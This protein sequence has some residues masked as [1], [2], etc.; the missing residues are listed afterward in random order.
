[1]H[2]HV[3][4]R[5]RFRLSLSLSLVSIFF[6]AACNGGI[7]DSSSELTR[8]DVLA[9]Q[10]LQEKH[11]ASEDE[12]KKVVQVFMNGQIDQQTKNSGIS[13]LSISSPEKIVLG[14]EN[15]F[16]DAADS[17]S[18]T[19]G[20]DVSFYLFAIDSGSE[21]EGFA[22]TCPDTRIGNLIAFA[23]SGQLDEDN[24]FTSVFYSKLIDYVENTMDTYNSVTEDDVSDALEKIENPDSDILTKEMSGGI[25][26]VGY[27]NDWVYNS[28][29]SLSLTNELWWGQ[30]PGY[31]DAIHEAYGEYYS[32][33]C[34]TTAIAQIMAY[35]EYPDYCD[36]SDFSNEDWY[37]NVSWCNGLSYTWPLMKQQKVYHWLPET[38]KIRVAALMLEIMKR[39]NSTFKFDNEGNYAGTSSY[40]SM[41]DDCFDQMGYLTPSGVCN[42]SLSKVKTSIN[43]YC[44]VMIAGD[45]YTDEGSEIG[46]AWVIDGYANM[47]CTALYLGYYPVTVTFDY[48]HC[49]LGWS[50]SSN[51][52]YISGIFDTDNLPHSDN[53]YY[54]TQVRPTLG[55]YYCYDIIIMPDIARP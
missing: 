43:A 5:V 23:P 8:K 31:N 18:D 47:S 16:K 55:K 13:G 11:Y 4:C 19:K 12:L 9:L 6:V 25:S 10:S 35:H 34:T 51:G 33:G 44:P 14:T 24:P 41:W 53:L 42:Y 22:L 46:H 32:T 20:E 30:S 27:L 54:S 15:S 2:K 45:R 39:L 3:S 36:L 49:N 38:G 50:G 52:F 17:K 7:S 21:K 28:G 48:V 40:P 37:Q 26:D 29:K 1:M